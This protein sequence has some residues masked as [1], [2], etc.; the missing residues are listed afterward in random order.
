MSIAQIKDQMKFNLR[1]MPLSSRGQLTSRGICFTSDSFHLKF[2]VCLKVNLDLSMLLFS[3]FK[4]HL[5]AKLHIHRYLIQI[6]IPQHNYACRIRRLA[7]FETVI[8]TYIVD[9][10]PYFDETGLMWG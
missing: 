6:T 8:N 3:I 1:S 7:T 9:T 5:E 4:Y 2:N 10:V